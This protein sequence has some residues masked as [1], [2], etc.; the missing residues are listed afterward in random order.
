MPNQV[1]F[2]V[3]V[4]GLRGVRAGEDFLGRHDHPVSS[5]WSAQFC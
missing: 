4:L 2:H 1:A 3:F 5:A